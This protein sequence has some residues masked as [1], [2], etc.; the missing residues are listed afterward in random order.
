MNGEFWSNQKQRQEGPDV[1]SRDRRPES[2][3]RIN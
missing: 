3:Q 2:E 1:E